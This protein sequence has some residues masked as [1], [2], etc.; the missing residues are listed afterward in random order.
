MKKTLTIAELKHLLNTKRQVFLTG[1][2]GTGKTYTLKMLLPHFKN[3]LKLATTNAAALRIG[4]NTVHSIFLLGIATS[5]D[6]LKAED[7]RFKNFLYAKLN[8]LKTILSKVDL[9]VIDEISML[10]N[11]V[12][13]LLFFRAEQ[14]GVN[15]PP[16]LMVGDLYQLPPI[17][18]EQ[19]L[20]PQKMIYHS[21]HFQPII[22]ELTSIKR[23]NDLAF[24]TAQKHIRKSQYNREV[25]NALYDI[26]NNTFED[27]FKP[28]ILTATNKE[29]D[30]INKMELDKLSTQPY[31]FD[32]NITTNIT[33]SNHIDSIIKSMPT[34]KTL[35]LKIGARVMFVANRKGVYYN[36][37]QGIVKNVISDELE[38]YIVVLTD[39]GNEIVVDKF[40]FEKLKLVVDDN[41]NCEYI[42]ELQMKQF[43]LKVAYAMT[44]HKSQGASIKELEI[45]CQNI[46]EAGQ[47]Y[48]AISRGTNPKFIK[49]KNFSPTHISIENKDLAHYME[50]VGDNIIYVDEIIE[51]E[52]I[53]Y[54]NINNINMAKNAESLETTPDSANKNMESTKRII[55]NA[56]EDRF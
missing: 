23:T 24:A 17:N 13:S 26:R 35:M 43:P 36:G 49:L 11:S 38:T 33:D 29:A 1:A 7:N 14:C 6:E 34:E 2:G 52:K 55:F 12:F 40:P 51:S 50:S 54:N 18:T 48:V 15:M 47:F 45:D 44:I 20:S 39:N 25:H 46:F 16:L 10:S 9:I 22:I 32:A 56:N 21:K 31:F 30:S 19:S 27:N 53:N 28:S 4:G 5:K 42:T 37:L 41:G 8:K 3:P